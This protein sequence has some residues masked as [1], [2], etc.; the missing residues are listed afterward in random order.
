VILRFRWVVI[1]KSPRKRRHLL[2]RV[3]ITSA[4]AGCT[5]DTGLDGCF[6]DSVQLE[7]VSS[8]TLWVARWPP[9]VAWRKMPTLLR[10]VLV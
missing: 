10:M 2:G 6:G 3:A 4:G 7:G 9:S 1:T 8:R 5:S